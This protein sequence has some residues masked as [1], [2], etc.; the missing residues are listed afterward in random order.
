[1]RK[2][3]VRTHSF[4]QKKK[5]S[6]FL[7]TCLC[8]NILENAFYCTELQHGQQNVCEIQFEILLLSLL[9]RQPSSPSATTS[10]THSFLPAIIFNYSDNKIKATRYLI[11]KTARYSTV[12]YSTV[13][14]GTVQYSKVWYG[15]V[16]YSTV[17]CQTRPY[18]VRKQTLF[19]K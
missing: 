3:E 4:T 18:T 19:L 16:Q 8:C 5:K 11:C 10:T 9:L 15:T 7:N 12:W 6:G 13:R 1:M 14:Y 2:E 17:P